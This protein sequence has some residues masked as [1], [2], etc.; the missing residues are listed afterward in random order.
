MGKNPSPEAYI[1]YTTTQKSNPNAFNVMLSYNYSG[2]KYQTDEEVLN[3]IVNNIGLNLSKRDLL[4]IKAEMSIKGSRNLGN[5]FAD[6]IHA[7]LTYNGDDQ[8]IKTTSTEFNS[9]VI[10]AISYVDA[11][12]NSMKTLTATIQAN[13]AS[14]TNAAVTSTAD[15]N[16]AT[17]A[18]W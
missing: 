18:Y 11:Q 12:I 5:Y 8:N 10:N 7:I 4:A 14:G 1:Y 13:T 9:R 6:F 15:L 3:T 2:K 17:Q 16:C